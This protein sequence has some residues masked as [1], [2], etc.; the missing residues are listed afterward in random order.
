MLRA[1]AAGRFSTGHVVPAI[2]DELWFFTI[3]VAHGEALDGFLV[4]AARSA[5]VTLSDDQWDGLADHHR[6]VMARVLAVD[7]TYLAVAAELDRIGIDHR[8]LKGVALANGLYADPAVRSYADADVL[9]EREGLQRGLDALLALGGRRLLP[10]VR[11]GFDTRFGKDITLLFERVPVDVH[12]TLIAGPYGE[13]L[14]I[15]RLMSRRREVTI[16]VRSAP[17]LDAADAYV[18][19]A[20]T[21]GAAD[22]PAKLVTLRDLLELEHAAGF[23]PELV[24]QRAQEWG[25]EAPVAR[26][27]RLLAE[28]L[29]PD[30]EPSLLGWATAYRPGHKDRLFMSC[31]TSARG[32][33]YRRALGVIVVLPTWRDR[34]TYTRAIALPQREYLDARRWTWRRHLTRALAR[35]RP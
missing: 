35:L 26:A 3:Q 29:R 12:R 6:S 24:R 34:A 5:L 21:A 14:P 32:R 33:S 31:Y 16:G 17:A 19:A 20:L 30:A 18:H 23:D 1:A 8:L 15:S 4:E 25:V 9:L 27:V 28:T 2:D 22:V 13:G 11:P 10:E 7:R